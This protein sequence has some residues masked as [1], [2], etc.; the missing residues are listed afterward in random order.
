M[1]SDRHLK[2]Y[3]AMAEEYLRREYPARY[4]ALEDPASHLKAMAARIQHRVA[5]E[6]ERLSL[7]QP[8]CIQPELWDQAER[9]VCSDLSWLVPSTDRTDPEGRTDETG[10]YLGWSDSTL[11]SLRTAEPDLTEWELAELDSGRDPKTGRYLLSDQQI[12]K[13]G[14]GTPRT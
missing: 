12:T 5:A 2:R 9:A 7:E 6:E 3:V 8:S 10:G 14:Q 11:R 4:Q 13:L 1:Q